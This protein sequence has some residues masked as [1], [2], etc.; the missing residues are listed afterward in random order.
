MA[1]P[2]S[3]A[4]PLPLCVTV[5]LSRDASGAVSGITQGLAAFGLME[6][7]S[8]GYAGAP[9][10]LNGLLLDLATYLIDAGAVLK[11]GETVGPDANTKWRVRHEVSRFLPGRMAYR[12][13]FA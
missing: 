13:Y 1:A 11:D 2:G 9:T 12:V 10:D 3:D 6:I 5:A 8:L 7:E 4:P